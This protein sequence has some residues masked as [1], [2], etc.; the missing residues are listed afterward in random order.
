MFIKKIFEGKADE[1]VHKQFV[2]FGKGQFNGR[3][4]I[5]VK[6]SDKINISTSF[7]FANELVLFVSGLASLFKVQ[8]IVLSKNQLER[9][10]GK[11]KQGLY[12]YQISKEIGSEELKQL[13]SCYAA[14]LDCSSPEGKIELRIKKK[15]PRP[16]PS[17]KS[18]EAKFDEKFCQLELENKFWFQ[19]H[20]EF[21]FDMPKELKKARIKHSY[22]IEEI[23]MPK[24]M[25]DFE[26]IRQE[27]KRK[28]KLI[29]KAIVDGKEL[30][31]EIGLLV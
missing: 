25:A 7:E 9:L 22:I 29:R 30:V 27:A 23:V 2:R 14:L 31:K 11:K 18:S 28:G 3:A 19:F 21:L 16:R 4:I 26:Q 1:S 20:D 12:S 15:I 24:G 13:A 8:G 10:Q 6:K 5:N 17:N